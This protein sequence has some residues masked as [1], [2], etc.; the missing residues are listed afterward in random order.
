MH[1]D[2]KTW[3]LTKEY[4]DNKNNIIFKDTF[5]LKRILSDLSKENAKIVK[6]RLRK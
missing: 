5:P 4:E 1:D 6:K 3:S 2:K